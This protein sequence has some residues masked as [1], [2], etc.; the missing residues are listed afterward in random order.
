LHASRQGNGGLHPSGV[1]PKPGPSPHGGIFD[2]PSLSRTAGDSLLP[3]AD[4]KSPVVFGLAGAVPFVDAVAET[5][6]PHKR[7]LGAV[8]PNP[9]PCSI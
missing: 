6:E 8:R 1:V 7:I 3:G 9:P 4:C 2:G 5:E